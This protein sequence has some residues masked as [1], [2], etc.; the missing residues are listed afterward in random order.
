MNGV[1]IAELPQLYKNVIVFTDTRLQ[2]PH[3]ILEYWSV[4]I[5]GIN[6]EKICEA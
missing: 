4:G 1:S 3:G 5:L 2:E 6:S